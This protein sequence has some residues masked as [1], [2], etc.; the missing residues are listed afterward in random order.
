MKTFDYDYTV[1][2]GDTNAMGNMY[3][4]NYF[5]LAGHVRELFVKTCVANCNQHLQ[6][7]LVLST[8]NAHCDFKIPFFLYDD[9]VVKVYFTCLQRV[10]VKIHFDFVMK[11]QEKLCASAWQTI[12]FKNASRKTCRMHDDFKKAFETYLCDLPDSD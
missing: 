9:L 6:N 2:M 1:T 7:N 8:K 3:Y 5:R 12:V 10:S 11:D 4:L